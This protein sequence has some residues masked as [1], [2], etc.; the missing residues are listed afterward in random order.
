MKE[1]VWNPWH[2]CVKYSEGCRNCYVY[3]R[4]ESIGKDP[5]AVQRN[6]AFD[7][8]IKKNR[9]GEYKV[10]SGS[11]LFTCLTSDFFLDMADAWRP[12]AWDMMRARPDVQFM[13]IT[14][15]ILRFSDCVPEDWG[16]GY[17]NVSV[18]CTVE[19]QRQCD[20]RLPVFCSLP[21]AG[22]K[23]IAC[24]PLLSDIDLSRYLS[25]EI[26]KV[27]AGGESGPGARMC[28]YDWVLHLRDQCLEAGVAFEY[29]QTGALLRKDGR[30]Y[31]IPRKIQHSQ[32]HKAGIDIRQK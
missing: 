9:A 16:D 18:I 21:V 25:D 24:E 20:I 1:D 23:Y 26:L 28:D 5:S 7:M 8:P 32:A 14:K 10:P 31:R 30:V 27:M 17:R 13:I 3:R 2:G 6:S 11:V 15:R 29:H 22:G 12:E 19:N 4:D